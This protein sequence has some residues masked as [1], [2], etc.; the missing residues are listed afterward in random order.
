MQVSFLSIPV[1]SM[2]PAAQEW[3]IERGWTRAYSRVSSIGLA[4]HIAY[5][6]AFM[7]CVEFGVYWMHRLLHDIRVGYRCAGGVGSWGFRVSAPWAPAGSPLVAR[8][9][10]AVCARPGAPT[11]TPASEHRLS[12]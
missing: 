9:S 12:D 11:V 6:V 3:V 7:A 8:R 10:P 2:L 4:R 1:Y 5:F